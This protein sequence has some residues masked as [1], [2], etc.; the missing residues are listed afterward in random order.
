R[1]ISRL[2]DLA[3][4]VDAH[5]RANAKSPYSQP[6]SQPNEVQLGAALSAMR[7]AGADE[8]VASKIA[9]RVRTAADFDLVRIRPF[10]LAEQISFDPHATLRAMLYAVHAGLLERRWAIVCP[11]C[12]TASEYA[13]ALDE[14]KTE[15]HCQLC[16][17]SFEVD[18]D[19]AVEATFKPHP[20]VRPV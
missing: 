19:R 13:S 2:K 16:D 18:L 15:G 5:V 14:I 6:T 8:A 9:D 12:L 3:L 10:Q 11:S 17:I 7:N 4:E 1:L 20:S